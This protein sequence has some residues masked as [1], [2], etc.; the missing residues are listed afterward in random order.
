MSCL[1]L[2][3]CLMSSLGTGSCHL[4]QLEMAS[5]RFAVSQSSLLISTTSLPSTKCGDPTGA[6]D[7]A[8]D[9]NVDADGG[10]VEDELDD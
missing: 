3:Q 10:D 6:T 5:S 1:D 7:G 4:S 9:G 2:S 8:E